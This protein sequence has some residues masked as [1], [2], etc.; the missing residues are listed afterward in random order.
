MA[1][2][3]VK[4]G[5]AK[6]CLIALVIGMQVCA[7]E[8]GLN[9]DVRPILSD[10]CFD[11]HGPDAGILKLDTTSSCYHE[12]MTHAQI[13]TSSPTSFQISITDI[14]RDQESRAR[15]CRYSV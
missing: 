7:A 12:G 10:K 1:L 4:R 13:Q 9:R 8:L 5:S 3:M 11:Y 14:H 15:T 6:V 2:M